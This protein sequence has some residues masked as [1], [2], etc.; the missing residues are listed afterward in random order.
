[1]IQTI[2]K[3]TSV[4]IVAVDEETIIASPGVSSESR[5]PAPLNWLNDNRQCV[6]THITNNYV[7]GLCTEQNIK[8]Q[9]PIL[10][11]PS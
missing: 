4:S 7:Y 5:S 9:V 10:G 11:M 1:M 3:R 8:Q 2:N 6:H